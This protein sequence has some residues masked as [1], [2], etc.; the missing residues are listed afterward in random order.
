MSDSFGIQSLYWLDTQDEEAPFPPVELALQDPDGLL[1]FGGDLGSRRLLRAYRQGIFPWYSEGQP[2][3]WWS[4][5]PR[6]VLFPSDL[7]VSRSL[8]KSMR[9]AG[10]SVT[11]NRAFERVI[12][13]CAAPRAEDDGTW[14]TTAM[15]DAYIRLHQEGHAHSI[16]TWYEGELVGGLYGIAIG[17]VFFGESM[18]ARR[19][20]ASKVAF[21][22][23]ARQ[24]ECW[25][26]ALID[27]QVHSDHLASLGATQIQRRQFIALLDKYCAG[28]PA[29][30][31]WQFDEAD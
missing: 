18:F 12:D 13:A 2:I 7:R 1:A 28:Q 25:G 23:L 6:T 9:N 27:C 30:R 20:D 22:R 17:R 11:M 8:R 24:L 19:R 31:F 16:E 29:M 10:Y 4:P 5:D 3:M 21:A 26:F 14:I 15:R